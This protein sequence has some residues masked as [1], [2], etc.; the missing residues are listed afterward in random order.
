MRSEISSKLSID[1]NFPRSLG[2]LSANTDLSVEGLASG[3][4]LVLR[5]AGFGRR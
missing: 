4:A 1:D 5:S 2:S 3:V